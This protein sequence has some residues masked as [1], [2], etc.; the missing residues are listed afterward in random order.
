MQIYNGFKNPVV[1]W[2]MSIVVNFI[3]TLIIASMYVNDEG[4][5]SAILAISFILTVLLTFIFIFYLLS[6]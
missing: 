6:H 5:V 1:I 4:S 2:L 3:S